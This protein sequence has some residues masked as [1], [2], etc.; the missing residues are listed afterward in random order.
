MIRKILSYM[1]GV[2]M[3]VGMAMLTSCGN[4]NSADLSSDRDSHGKAPSH[5]LRGKEGIRK[6]ITCQ[7]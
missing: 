7:H 5:L 3:V 2:S 6:A 1:A 4:S